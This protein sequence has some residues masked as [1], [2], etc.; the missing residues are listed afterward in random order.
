MT[1]ES[2]ISII[3]TT[4]SLAKRPVR[5]ALVDSTERNRYKYCAIEWSYNS[6]PLSYT[7][8]TDGPPYDMNF[9]P[10]DMKDSQLG[11]AVVTGIVPGNYRRAFNSLKQR[12]DGTVAQFSSSSLPQTASEGNPNGT[13]LDLQEIVLCPGDQL[14]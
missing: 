1:G 13:P 9:G 14:I 2:S 10:V 6:Y 11:R 5:L 7:M 12:S 8:E 3:Q 4:T